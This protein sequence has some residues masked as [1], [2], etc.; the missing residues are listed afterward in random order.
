MVSEC[1]LGLMWPHNFNDKD[2]TLK[3]KH[4]CRFSAKLDINKKAI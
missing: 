3:F 1:R 2:P 4:E